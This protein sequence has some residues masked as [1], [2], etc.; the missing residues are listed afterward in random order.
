M[1]NSWE[2]KSKTMVDIADE[3]Y[4]Q[5]LCIDATVMKRVI[6]LKRGVDKEAG[7]RSYMQFHPPAAAIILSASSV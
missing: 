2:K 7:S 6:T 5:M 4:K 3:E 1:W